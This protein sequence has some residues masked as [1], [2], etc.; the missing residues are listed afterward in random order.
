MI[1][2]D[3][4]KDKQNNTNIEAKSKVVSGVV[5]SLPA[6]LIGGPMGLMAN[7]V[8][9][10]INVKEEIDEEEKRKQKRREMLDNNAIKAYSPTTHETEMMIKDY[11]NKF[12]SI[13]LTTVNS[14]TVYKGNRFYSSSNNWIIPCSFVFKND[15]CK[16]NGY[17]LCTY[18]FWREFYKHQDYELK[19][20]R[21]RNGKE[22]MCFTKN[23]VD[24]YFGSYI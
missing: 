13:G 2:G 8:Y 9:T 1:G 19:K 24:Y 12:K 18:D 16:R 15:D 21:I 23:G 20:Y 6:F 14:F 7:A 4:L 17:I 10:T 5:R 11:R 3:Y 22:Y